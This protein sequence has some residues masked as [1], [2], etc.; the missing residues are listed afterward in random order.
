M[1][2]VNKVI[3]TD[4]VEKVNELL[5]SGWILLCVAPSN[6]K[7]FSFCL[8]FPIILNKTGNVT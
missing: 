5:D 2:Q 6:K 7:H 1:K 3:E 8:G 4:S